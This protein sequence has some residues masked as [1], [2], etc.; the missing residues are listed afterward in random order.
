MT[1]G[2]E[3]LLWAGRI[4]CTAFCCRSLWLNKLCYLI[5]LLCRGSAAL[6]IK[7]IN[8]ICILLL[9]PGAPE[10]SPAQ[11]Q[12]SLS[13]Y[14]LPL[15]LW[16]WK[17]DCTLH[18]RLIEDIKHLGAD[19]EGRKVSQGLVYSLLCCRQPLCCTSSSV[20]CPGEHLGSLPSCLLA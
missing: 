9:T 15:S 1:H 20:F 6:S 13:V 19:I 7:F 3:F 8:L 5:T 4:S 2:V 14:S 10:Q 16:L 12:S 17:A 11:S 18:H